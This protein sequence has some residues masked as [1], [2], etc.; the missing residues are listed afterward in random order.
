M[1]KVFS[2]ISLESDCRFNQPE[3]IGVWFFRL[4]LKRNG[5]S[6]PVF[7]QRLS[8]SEFHHRT[9]CA[10][11]L[12]VK[13]QSAIRECHVGDSTNQAGIMCDFGFCS[14]IRRI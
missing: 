12:K 1:G 3:R 11:P 14:V 7:A 4:R 10:V 6:R 13:T 9:A 2:L 5:A 8:S